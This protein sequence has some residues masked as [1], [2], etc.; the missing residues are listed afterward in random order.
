[1]E[2][3]TIEKEIFT[4]VF[5]WMHSIKTKTKKKKTILINLLFYYCSFF[6][7]SL[8][9]KCSFFFVIQFC[10]RNLKTNTTNKQNI[11]ETSKL[12]SKHPF[13]YRL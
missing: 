8:F 1:M 9:S 13:F 10:D 5:L 6:F 2:M 4:I 12:F 3:A 11:K 7:S